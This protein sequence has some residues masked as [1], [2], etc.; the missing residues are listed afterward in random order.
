MK[1]IFFT[2]GNVLCN[3]PVA[4]HPPV[5]GRF[6]PHAGHHRLGPTEALTLASASPIHCR[7]LD[8]VSGRDEVVAR[9]AGAAPLQQL[10]LAVVTYQLARDERL[11]EAALPALT[12][13]LV[14]LLPMILLSRTLWVR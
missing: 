11:G 13:V 12:L 3:V 7:S 8:G 1:C 14:G 5:P 10:L 9:H 4:P 2:V 6:C